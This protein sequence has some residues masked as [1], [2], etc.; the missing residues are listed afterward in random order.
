MTGYALFTKAI[1]IQDDV[2]YSL[3]DREYATLNDKHKK[4]VIDDCVDSRLV[5]DRALTYSE[6]NELQR[7]LEHDRM[8]YNGCDRQHVNLSADEINEFDFLS[9]HG[10][11]EPPNWKLS[12]DPNGSMMVDGLRSPCMN[13]C[14]HRDCKDRSGGSLTFYDGVFEFECEKEF[15]YLECAALSIREVVSE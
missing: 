5:R 4:V 1:L 12:C 11:E 14:Y 7:K 2:H 15:F 10:V 9:I 6:S 3:L 8:L 13:V